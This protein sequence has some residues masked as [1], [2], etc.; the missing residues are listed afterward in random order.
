M[1]FLHLL[2]LLVLSL[3]IVV[4]DDDYKELKGKYTYFTAGSACR[5]LGKEWRIPEIWE[6][7]VLK[8][9]TKRFG[10]DKR[11]WSANTLGETRT[12]TLSRHG[13]EEF[14]NDKDNPAYAFYLQDGDI[15]PTPKAIKANVLCTAKPQV[16]QSDKAFTLSEKGVSDTFNEIIWEPLTRKNRSLKFNFEQARQYCE[17]K[18][19]FDRSW[20]LPTL[21]ELYSIVNYG[22]VK[23][24]CNKELFGNMQL[25]Y[26]WSDDEFDSHSSY[27]VGFSIG[28]VATSRQSNQSYVRCVSDFE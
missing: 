21:E 16:H 14:R 24:S 5:A 11:Y 3:S 20:R 1:K 23:P 8:G 2:L 25:K 7:F 26:Y 4:A 15:T 6:L 22:F 10:K 27:V 13:T 28:S 18:T 19:L 9:E 12:L 17:N